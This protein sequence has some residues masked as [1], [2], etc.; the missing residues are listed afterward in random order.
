MVASP[1]KTRIRMN[2][3]LTISLESSQPILTISWFA[4]VTPID[5]VALTK[6]IIIWLSMVLI[7]PN[8]A[9]I[10]KSGTTITKVG[11]EIGRFFNAFITAEKQAMGLVQEQSSNDA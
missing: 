1:M 10:T 8:T 5:I 4:G 7:V 2:K 6:I 9:V 11:I 3:R